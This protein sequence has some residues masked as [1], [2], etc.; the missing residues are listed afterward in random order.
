MSPLASVIPTSSKAY[1]STGGRLV[2]VDGKVLPLRGAS[3]VADARAGVARVTLVQTFANSHDEPM[4]V[5]YT[6]PLP[7]DGAVS[8]FRFRLGDKTIVGEIDTRQKARQRFEDAVLEGKTAALLDQE[9][10]SLFTQEVGNVPPRTEVTCETVIDQK[11]AWLPDGCWEWRFPTVVAPRYLGES[12]RVA[13]AAKVTVDVAD[14]ALPVKL[15]LSLSVR[16]RLFADARP[17]SPSHALHTEGG[18]GRLDVTLA[19]DRGASLDRDVVVRWRTA[20]VT[21][22][23]ALDV[24][25]SYRDSI[26]GAAFGL[27]T[28]VPPMPEARMQPLPRDLIVLLDTSGSMGGLPLDQARRITSALVDSLGDDD[29][30]ELIEFSNS[31]RRWKSGAVKASAA[32]RK[33]AQAWLSKLVASGGT[34]MRSGILEALA[35]LREGAQRQVVLITDGLIGSE[36]EVL[37][38]IA[39]RLPKG[40]RVHTVGV[41][42]AVNR[43]LTQPAARAGR[44][45][46]LVFGLGEDAEVAVKRILSRTNAPLVTEVELSGTAVKAV[47]P[48][49]VPDLFA[50]APALIGLELDPKGGSIVLKGRTAD[51]AF[52]QRLEVKPVER[53]EGSQAVPALFAREKVEDL[54]LAWALDGEAS[55]NKAIEKTGLDFQISTRHTSWIAVSEEATV[56]PRAPKRTETMPQELAYGISAEGV[57]LRQATSPLMAGPMS[58]ASLSAP[59][60]QGAIRGR[61]ASAGAP[62]GPPRMKEMA[63]LGGGG[64]DDESKVA[65]RSEAPAPKPAAP[66]KARKS[67]T[68]L[69]RDAFAPKSKKDEAPPA[70]EEQEFFDAA[71]APLEDEEPA[72]ELPPFGLTQGP[73]AGAPMQP[74]ADKPSPAPAPPSATRFHQ[75]ALTGKGTGA[76]APR[77]VQGRLVRNRDGK[78]VVELVLTETTMWAPGTEASLHFADGSMLKVKVIEAL[79]TAQGSYSTGLTVTVVLEVPAGLANPSSVELHVGG[80]LWTISL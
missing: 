44:G 80:G 66:A 73:A 9:R 8:G 13:D 57:G 15:S 46:E 12:G 67:L 47:A 79:T 48:K 38:A 30:L 20:D 1:E 59:M 4:R 34:E 63:S 32:N 17:F 69:V 25:R 51:G 24:G 28:L 19:D 37:R 23:A 45:V 27:L 40:S 21:V 55:T 36:D 7:A 2:A 77:A 75:E 60:M 5:T 16:D 26:A 33:A 14:K 54:E 35:P 61:M 64:A 11:L 3:L 41:G 70:P 72:A 56:D 74:P 71:A 18:L 43:S 22:G 10:S 76:P 6:L 52:E 31:P 49:H 29:Q 65:R 39:T 42:S 68:D 50:G 78:L 53:G 58:A 62:S